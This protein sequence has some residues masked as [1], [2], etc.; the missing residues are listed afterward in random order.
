MGEL[1]EGS[2]AALTVSDFVLNLHG[3]AQKRPSLNVVASSML[4]SR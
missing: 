3:L 1:M 2:G 4:D